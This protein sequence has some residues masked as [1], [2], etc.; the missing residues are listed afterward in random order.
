MPQSD[1]YVIAP[2][3]RV[4]VTGAAGFIGPKVI[5]RLV[6]FGFSNIRAFVRPSSDVRRLKSLIETLGSGPRIEI[7]K[8]NLLSPQDC[9][10][11]VKDVAVI[12]HLATSGDKSFP[13]SFLNSVVTT[14]NLLECASLG[15]TLRR[16]VNV[17]SFAVYSNRNKRTGRLLD[18]SAPVESNSAPRGDAYCYA[19]IKQEELV[20]EYGERLKI[21][22]VMLRPG[23][24]YGPG[25]TNI[26]GR[27]GIDSFGPFLHMGG[28]NQIPFTYVDN[29]A[30]AIVLAGV[31]PG[32]E[33]EVFNVVDDDLFSS[34][35]F[36]R[37][38]KRK[39]RRFSSL[40]VPHSMSYILCRLWEAY[41]R[42]SR[43][44]LPPA[45]NRMRWHAEWKRTRY[46]NAKLKR[47]LGWKPAVSTR[48]GMERYF[49]YCREKLNA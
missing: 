36:L 29:C 48:D 34:R 28:S 13:A 6:A 42:W 7:V 8:G 23:S 5:E 33:G 3:D 32:V 49:G 2:H 43:G 27:V 47:L 37:L 46:S 45:F 19:K 20:A 38:Y 10:A 25:K 41:S 21:P 14:R 15:G 30:D 1:K 24:V 4:L 39:V 44:Q 16:F 11:A 31:V 9:A 40:Y 12:F 22:Y 18:E 35:K 17:S 26:T